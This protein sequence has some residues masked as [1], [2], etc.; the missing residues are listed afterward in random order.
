MNYRRVT[1]QLGLL[2]L[3]FGT[4]L[5]TMAAFA[6]LFDAIEHEQVNVSAERALVLSCL[7]CLACGGAAWGLTRR[8]D[9]TIGRRDALL[10]VSLSWGL[11]AV[12]AALPFH[13]WA[14]SLG[15]DVTPHAFADVVN[16]YFEAMSGLTTTGATV[17]SDIESI[18][19]ELLMWR[20]F[21]HWIGGLGIVVLFVAVLPSLGVGAKKLFIVESPGPTPTGLRPRVAQTARTLW[22]IYV[23]LTAVE[24][25]ALWLIGRMPIFDSICHAFATLATGGFSTQNASLGAYANWPAIDGIVLLFMVLAGANFRALRPALAVGGSAPCGE[26]QNS[27]CTSPYLGSPRSSSVAPCGSEAGRSQ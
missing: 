23:A 5:G 11:G 25:L 27:A 16:C 9:P 18:P 3:V 17:L 6:W 7:L 2:L 21:T 20:A 1:N 10:L 24:V 19:R 8:S 22:I 14:R 13:L 15:P 12:F 4:A 26:T